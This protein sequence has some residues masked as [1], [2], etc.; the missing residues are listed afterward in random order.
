MTADEPLAD[1]EVL[2]VRPLEPLDGRG[3]PGP[4][5]GTVSRVRC[6]RPLAYPVPVADLPP[7]LRRRAGLGHDRYA[8][9]FFAFDLDVLPPGQRYTGARLD[10]TLDDPGARAVQLAADGDEFGLVQSEPTSPVAVRTVAAA[11]YRP[12]LLRRLGRRAGAPRAWTTGL[13]SATFGWVYDDPWGAALL[14]RTY[15]MH[16]LIEISP[17]ATGLSGVLTVQTEVTGGTPLTASVEFDEPFAPAAPAGAAVRLCLAADVVGYSRHGNAAAEELQ[18][19]LVE[20]LAQARRAAGIA[21]SG[22]HTQPQGDGQF[23]VLPTGIDESAVIPRMIA[24]L[25]AGLLDRDR[26]RAAED[27]MRLRVALHRGLVKEAANGWIGTSAIA[28]HRIL[29]SPPLRAAIKDNPE[30]AYV[31]GLPDV[32]YRDVIAH[33]VEPPLPADFRPMTMALPE[34]DFVEQGWVMVGA[35]R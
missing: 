30:A 26:G 21:D 32:L 18:R 19:D 17:G 5:G 31:L 25:G 12:A 16:A 8:G 4:A 7:V 28:V 20:V 10:V 3:A 29:D 34:K 1:D 13:Q 2:A 33:A 14:P 9:V 15:G 22:V 24:R 23:S 6:G 27:R 11:R 35:A